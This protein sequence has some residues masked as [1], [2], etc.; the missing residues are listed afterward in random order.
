[1]PP[2]T[3]NMPVRSEP[4][5]PLPRGPEPY[6]EMDRTFRGEPGGGR[7]L[8]VAMAASVFRDL[9]R[10]GHIPAG[11]R[12]SDEPPRDPRDADIRGTSYEARLVSLIRDRDGNGRLDL[13]LDRLQRSGILSRSAT[14][15]ELESSIG[16]RQERLSDQ[17]VRRQNDES[18][19]TSY[20]SINDRGRR[21]Q[22]YSS[23]MDL[24]TRQDRASDAFLERA[25]T[26][27]RTPEGARRIATEASIQAQALT[28]RGDQR[29]AQELLAGTGDILQ[30]N[31]QYT[32][33]RRV[34]SELREPPY[35]DTRVNLVQREHDA[36]VRADAAYDPRREDMRITSGGN[37]TRLRE[38][39][40][41]STYG[42]LA[43]RRIAQMDQADRMSAVLGRR[44]DPSDPDDA[45]AYFTSF[46]RGRST[47][48]VRGEYQQY[49]QN[50][51]AHAGSGVDWSPSI[52]PD[53]RPGRVRELFSDQPRDAAGRRIIDCE[54]YTYLTQHVLGGARDESGQ[55]RFEFLHA[56]QP[57]HVVAGVFD[58]GGGG[59]SVND[60]RTEMFSG[61]VR[62]PNDR[63]NAMG[64]AISPGQPTFLNVGPPSS[65]ETLQEDGMPRDGAYIWNGQQV[66]GVVDEFF[67]ERFREAARERG[68]PL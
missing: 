17:F 61:D 11:A 65:C 23:A 36:M 25:R 67:R 66:T 50:F 14:V 4:R 45:R 60:D 54:G 59:F 35:R 56:G 64:N 62:A 12:L 57:G 33:A 8:E 10:S 55:S 30:N 27:G 40:F 47:D 41:D 22:D 68:I 52:P 20:G 24:R 46:S 58:R 21:V 53:D 26:E 49:M 29:R 5:Q 1:M 3:M 7:D 43:D 42:Q 13:D 6:V 18:N 38:R 48:E 44:V 2:P 32:S 37:V 9:Q 28:G 16:G 15:D 34:Y 63:L 31:G 39:S 19:L 51:Y